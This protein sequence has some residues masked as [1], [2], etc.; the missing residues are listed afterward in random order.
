MLYT[1]SSLQFLQQW[2]SLWRRYL[3][4]CTVVAMLP[5][6]LAAQPDSKGR[7][8]YVSFPPNFHDELFDNRDSLYL[9]I[10]AEQPTEGLIVY[11]DR[12]GRTYRH[13]F[14][15]SNPTNVY[16]FAVPFED[17]EINGLN[18][19][20]TIPWLYEQN[21]E[22]A[23]QSFHITTDEDVTVYG[24]NQGKKTSDAM[25]VLPTDAL[26][27][28][29]RILSYNSN[30]SNAGG[31]IEGYSTPSQFVVVAT[32]DN[33]EIRITPSQPTWEGGT[34]A[35]VVV[36]NKGEA[37]LV[38]ASISEKRLTTD[39]TG[40]SVISSK[41][42]A[43]FSG[44]QR[45]TIPIE[46][47]ADLRTRDYLLEQLPPLEAWGYSAIVIPYPAPHG[48]EDHGHDIVRVLA[49][50]DSTVIFTNGI[51]A[52]VLN[53]GVYYEMSLR[54]ALYITASAPILVAQYKKTARR[55][56]GT[57]E[58]TGDPFMVIIPPQEQF[59][60]SYRF[61]NA[62]VLKDELQPPFNQFRVYQEQYISLIAPQS[63]I[64]TV[65]IDN[66]PVDATLF[67]TIPGSPMAYAHI[68]MED[69]VHTVT[70]DTGVGLQVYGYG[71]ADSYGYAGGMSVKII[72]KDLEIP[73]IYADATCRVM[74]GI[75][76]DSSGYN[77]GI[78]SIETPASLMENI[79][80]EA[81]PLVD[82]PRTAAFMARLANPYNDGYFTLIARDSVR[83]KS[84][85]KFT[86]YGYTVEATVPGSQRRFIRDTTRIRKE[87]CLQVTVTNYGSSQQTISRASFLD[88][89]RFTWKTPLPIVLAPGQSQSVQFCF[90]SNEAG[91][92]LDTLVINDSCTERAVL[93]LAIHA[94]ND[95]IQPHVSSRTDSCAGKLH[96][97]ITEQ[98]PSDWGIETLEL[99]STANCTVDIDRS[100]IPTI[101]RYTA[102]VLNPL[103]DALLVLRVVDEAG[104]E[105][106]VRDTIQGFA[107]YVPY[108]LHTVA[109][110]PPNAY[111][112][113]SIMLRNTS[114]LPL[115]LHDIYCKNNTHFSLPLSQFPIVIPPQQTAPLYI[116]FQPTGRRTYTDTVLFTHNCLP[117][118]I[119][120]QASEALT[121]YFV[122]GRC[123][124]Q[125]VFSNDNDPH[126]QPTLSQPSPHPADGSTTVR[127]GISHSGTLALRLY[128][129]S[130]G[131]AAE[132]LEH[133]PAA[134]TYD[135]VLN[136]SRLESG[137]Y[138]CEVLLGGQ[139]LTQ[140][141][142]V[143][144]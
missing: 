43:V 6:V 83:L 58:N 56:G 31:R 102:T 139:R 111:K 116:V 121:E 23:L 34:T 106:Y 61:V 26:G 57:Q 67:Q 95:T 82:Y 51:P 30:G 42:V 39:L 137:V 2:F 120:V 129:L 96:G 11:R 7:D 20:G 32:E 24:L 22:M 21:E 66:T 5:V 92:Y 125:L 127:V 91:L 81:D 13:P 29:Y 99:L 132:V 37:F 131:K 72:P 80:F 76:V 130:G 33:T 3:L 15:M 12:T 46:L 71:D 117:A 98:L 19:S 16:T 136:T 103:D 142:H 1:M 4:L 124:V 68:T 138:L 8:F 9:Y 49:L 55:Q 50:Y 41:P 94:V 88:A 59:L 65:R 35:R 74:R 73:R 78:R 69:G 75:V 114:I 133:I 108:P 40:T 141:L 115:R 36:L 86:I 113:D 52:I 107:L 112:T 14:V 79:V 54:Q 126:T 63:H 101:A 53:E 70:A 28:Y 77:S 62:Q 47:A 100:T 123:N 122:A 135:I 93:A 110:T 45:A 48:D 89:D 64:S 128:T 140:L 84:R 60:S 134:G 18:Y 90:A 38:Q 10:A 144:H 27:R 104:N 25:L 105:R 87:L 119:V 109:P 17:F 143:L 44:H 85:Q 118:S 97:T